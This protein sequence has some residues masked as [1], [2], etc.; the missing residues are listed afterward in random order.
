MQVGI[1][2]LV[3]LYNYILT[4]KR[5]FILKIRKVNDLKKQDFT[6]KI[7]QL[8]E[9]AQEKDNQLTTD[10]IANMF[11]EDKLTVNQQQSIIPKLTENKIQIIEVV[12]S[13]DDD[14]IFENEESILDDE[15]DISD[16][17]IENFDEDIDISDDDIDISDDD[18][19]MVEVEVV[20]LVLEPTDADLANAEDDEDLVGAVDEDFE[21]DDEPVELDAVD[22]LE[23]VGTEDPVRM[24]LKEIGTVPLLTAEEE[25]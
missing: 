3:F 20:D 5:Y 10:D 7:Q 25:L 6:Q 13:Q 21:E 24:Y 1:H 23:G 14:D 15:I 4:G 17:D 18:V 22:L 12:E 11:A 8:V 16:E 9:M 19:E 2:R